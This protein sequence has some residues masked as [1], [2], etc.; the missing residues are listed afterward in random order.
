MRHFSYYALLTN[1][2]NIAEVVVL[3]LSHIEVWGTCF[4][5]IFSAFSVMVGWIAEMLFM[6]FFAYFAV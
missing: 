6:L 3:W 5:S 1:E 2:F 4:M